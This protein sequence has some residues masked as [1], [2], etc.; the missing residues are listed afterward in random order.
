MCSNSPTCVLSGPS[1]IQEHQSVST[2]SSEVESSSAFF[3]DRSLHLEDQSTTPPMSSH[4]RCCPM[5]GILPAITRS[6]DIVE[7]EPQRTQQLSSP[8]TS[9]PSKSN[10]TCGWKTSK[11]FS[12]TMSSG[13]ILRGLKKLSLTSSGSSSDTGEAESGRSRKS[14]SSQLKKRSSCGTDDVVIVDDDPKVRS[15]RSPGGFRPL[16]KAMSVSEPGSSSKSSNLGIVCRKEDLKAILCTASKKFPLASPSKRRRGQ[17]PL[18]Q[19]KSASFDTPEDRATRKEPV[20]RAGSE[21]PHARCSNQFLEN[22]EAHQ[23]KNDNILDQS[24]P[25]AA[26]PNATAVDNL[27][28][29]NINFDTAVD[30]ESK[31]NFVEG[32]LST[33]KW[34]E[35][36]V[37]DAVIIGDAIESFL[38]GSM[39]GGEKKVSF[40]RSSDKKTKSE[41]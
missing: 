17:A 33:V 38:K 25:L 29:Q 30:E 9:K 16:S 31:S 14:K 15:P 34:D 18:R 19:T 23:M 3:C 37:V 35:C 7:E 28:A 27:N 11:F 24:E 20:R 21:E 8:S 6:H 10:K 12:R 32:S 22:N 13:E 26:S 2:I 41:G 39:S 4:S 5:T 40:R 1:C 36:E